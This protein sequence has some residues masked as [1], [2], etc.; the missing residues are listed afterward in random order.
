[1]SKSTIDLAELGLLEIRTKNGHRGLAHGDEIILAPK[2]D[3]I[4]RAWPWRNGYIMIVKDVNWFYGI[5]FWPGKGKATVWMSEYRN[6][7][8]NLKNGWFA[9]EGADFLFDYQGNP[10]K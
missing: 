8:V 2:Y 1:M 3:H 10:Q 7:I 9:A 4:G 5:A 6:K